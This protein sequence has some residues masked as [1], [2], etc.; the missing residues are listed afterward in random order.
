M[1]NAAAIEK[2][3]QTI[4]VLRLEVKCLQRIIKELSIRLGIP[5]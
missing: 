3:R 2:L 1:K 5:V 4:Y